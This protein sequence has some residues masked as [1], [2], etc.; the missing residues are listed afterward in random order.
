MDASTPERSPVRPN[1][2]GIAYTVPSGFP[3]P[4]RSP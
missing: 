3:E 4:W 2:S 1:P